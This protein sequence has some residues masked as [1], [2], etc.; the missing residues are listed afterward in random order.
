MLRQPAN[1]S[2]QYSPLEWKFAKILKEAFENEACI[3]DD[4]NYYEAKVGLKIKENQDYI[5][6]ESNQQRKE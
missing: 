6:E 1:Q 5:S 4:T 3:I 2:G